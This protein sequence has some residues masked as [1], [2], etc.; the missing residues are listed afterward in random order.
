M[1]PEL[2]TPQLSPVL[3]AKIELV[4]W[5]I[6]PLARIAAPAPPAPAL[7]FENVLLVTVPPWSVWIAPPPA[8]VLPEK[9]QLLTVIV[10]VPL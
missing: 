3:L 2:T 7:L 5:S 8:A 9:V 10:P 6:V 4:T 1:T